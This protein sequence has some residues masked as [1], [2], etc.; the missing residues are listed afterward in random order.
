MKTLYAKALFS[1][2]FP[3]IFCMVQCTIFSPKLG[4]LSRYIIRKDETRQSSGARLVP[5]LRAGARS[6]HFTMHDYIVNEIVFI[7][8][9]LFQAR[10]RNV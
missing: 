2:L 1:S 3:I 7:S 8:E 6:T 10:L 9:L 5:I 4:F